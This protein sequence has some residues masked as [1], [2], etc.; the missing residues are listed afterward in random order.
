MSLSKT[1]RSGMRGRWQPRGWVSWRV[2]S[3]AAI[4]THSGSRMDD[5]RAGTRPP[6]VTGAWKLRDHHGS[7]LPCS[8]T[9]TGAGPKAT[10][11]LGGPGEP[12]RVRDALVR[13]TG[14]VVR[15]QPGTDAEQVGLF[16]ETLNQHLAK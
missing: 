16:H 4:W 2:G 8:T 12:A 3:S 15:G 6:M 11:Q 1:T 13:L 7:C 9:P 5:G 14:L 10:S